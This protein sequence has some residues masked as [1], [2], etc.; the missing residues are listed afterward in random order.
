MFCNGSITKLL[1]LL[2]QDRVS[3]DKAFI[4][5][6]F[7]LLWET[8]DEEL[9]QLKDENGTDSQ[10]NDVDNYSSIST[11]ISLPET[12]QNTEPVELIEPEERPKQKI[13][14]EPK[15]FR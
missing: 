9:G 6:A 3:Y 14:V 11:T 15:N 4:D 13:Q 5:E 1:Y 12:E 8:D 2:T 10:Y 7:S